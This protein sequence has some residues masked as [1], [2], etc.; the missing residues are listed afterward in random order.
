MVQIYDVV[1][2]GTVGLPFPVTPR[3]PSVASFRCLPLD[4]AT[5]VLQRRRHWVEWRVVSRPKAIGYTRLLWNYWILFWTHS[6]PPLETLYT[7]MHFCSNFGQFTCLPADRSNIYSNI[8]V[9]HS[10]VSSG[11]SNVR[12]MV[13]CTWLVL[14]W[15]DVEICLQPYWIHDGLDFWTSDRQGSTPGINRRSETWSS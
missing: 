3:L 13:N 2:Y 7:N 5:V 10:T 1:T 11:C 12:N 14:R 4:G 8:Y 6:N 9:D 15:N